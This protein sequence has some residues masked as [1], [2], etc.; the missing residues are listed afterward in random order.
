MGDLCK[1]PRL[2]VLD[3]ASASV[4]MMSASCALLHEQLHSQPSFLPNFIRINYHLRTVIATPKPQVF[5]IFHDQY[6]YALHPPHP[7][8]SLPRLV[9][10]RF[11]RRPRCH[12]GTFGLTPDALCLSRPSST[13]ASDAP[14]ACVLFFGMAVDFHCER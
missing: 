5:P 3:G 11:G 6:L 10:D 9:F 12:H 14:Q 13:K 7:Y 8:P 2:P 1:L 4:A